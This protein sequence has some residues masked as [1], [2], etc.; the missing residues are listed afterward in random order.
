MGEKLG[1]RDRAVDFLDLV[2]SLALSLICATMDKFVTRK[3]KSDD[4]SPID[5]V[6]RKKA[7]DVC[8]DKVTAEKLDCDYGLIYS[9]EEGDK[10][11]KMCEDEISYF[12][13]QLSRV[14]VFGKWH[15]IPRKQVRK[16]D[17]S[18]CERASER[19]RI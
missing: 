2:L 11:L 17:I 4:S 8:L 10:L 3:R 13:G 12:T 7:T 9:R 14:F 1:A 18:T 19:A 6:K 15:D 16:L 5:D